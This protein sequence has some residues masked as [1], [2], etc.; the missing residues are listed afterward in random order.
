MNK[1]A[2]SKRMVECKK[3]KKKKRE[4]IIINYDFKNYYFKNDIIK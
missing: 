4:Y 2:S 3:K 1:L